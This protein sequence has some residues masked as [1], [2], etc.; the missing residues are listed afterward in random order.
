MR[1]CPPDDTYII[2]GV[3]NSWRRWNWP[4][5][6]LTNSCATSPR[7]AGSASRAR[8]AL[9]DGNVGG[10]VDGHYQRAEADQLAVRQVGVAETLAVIAD[11][12]A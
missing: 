11:G 6:S 3:G 10:N 1:V 4:A 12:W 2:P 7:C 8:A 5:W 9:G